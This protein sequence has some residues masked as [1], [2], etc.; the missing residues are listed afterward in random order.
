MGTVGLLRWNPNYPTFKVQGHVDIR[1]FEMT[2][3]RKPIK[4]WLD[5]T[6]DEGM[7]SIKLDHASGVFPE[8]FKRP[9]NTTITRHY[10]FLVT[11]RNEAIEGKQKGP[12]FN[13]EDPPPPEEV[14]PTPTNSLHFAAPI[15][16]HSLLVNTSSTSPS[17]TPAASSITTHSTSNDP[18]NIPIDES[19]DTNTPNARSDKSNM[20]L[21]SP[22]A[23]IGIT[24]GAIIGLK[25][26]IRTLVYYLIRRCDRVNFVNRAR[27]PNRNHR[28]FPPMIDTLSR[29]VGDLSRYSVSGYTS[30]DA[31][32]P[33]KETG[34]RSHLYSVNSQSSQ[35]ILAALPSN[36]MTSSQ[37]SPT[38]QY[39][40]PDSLRLTVKDAQLIADTYRRLLR[41]PSWTEEEGRE[42]GKRNTYTDELLRRE[43][44]AEGTGV[45]QV[46]TAPTIV[47]VNEEQKLNRQSMMSIGQLEELPVQSAS[48][49]KAIS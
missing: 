34:N 28:N 21:I 40:E 43:L 2:N 8:G 36:S 29:D 46:S 4:E 44:E 27:A 10:R 5:I 13:I 6:N 11:V 16:N 1:L 37:L 26:L 25:C 12:I 41:K 7:W 31:F 24:A 45:K 20:S 42:L 18:K 14:N 9:K 15:T 30:T 39:F 32:L 35:H 23:A 17:S 47:I 38:E 19:F 3:P 22:A 49:S 33:V 48:I